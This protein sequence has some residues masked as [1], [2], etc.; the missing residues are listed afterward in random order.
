M[1][2]VKPS[3]YPGPDSSDTIVRWLHVSNGN[4]IIN[5]EDNDDQDVGIC[6]YLVASSYFKI[7][8]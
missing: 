4:D 1:I 6:Q 3:R 8:F 7:Q 2:S 5:E